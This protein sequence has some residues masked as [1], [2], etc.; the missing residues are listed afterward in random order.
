MTRPC[1]GQRKPAG[2]SATPA[3]TDPVGWEA[4]GVTTAAL[5]GCDGSVLATGCFGVAGVVGLTAGAA[6]FPGAA[7]LASAIFGASFGAARSPGIT[8]RSPIF[9]F[10]C[11]GMLLALATST[12]LLL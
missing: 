8:M 5:S 11:G 10:V 1:T 3:F 4:S 6:G 7:S 2:V 12:R 9:T